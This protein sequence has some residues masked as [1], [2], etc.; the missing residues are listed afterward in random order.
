MLTG[1]S[2][3]IGPCLKELTR[4]SPLAMKKTNRE[5]E[6]PMPF[7]LLRAGDIDTQQIF[8]KPPMVVA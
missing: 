6:Q 7:E 2:A 3:M 1:L 8:V 4:L 5:E